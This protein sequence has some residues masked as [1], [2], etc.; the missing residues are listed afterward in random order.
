M[1]FAKYCLYYYT[2]SSLISSLFCCFETNSDA[3]QPTSSTGLVG[4]LPDFVTHAEYRD[5][6]IGNGSH[7]LQIILR[8]DRK[9]EF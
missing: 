9:R 2:G 8:T 1:R 7:L 3:H 4:N 6:L 5:H